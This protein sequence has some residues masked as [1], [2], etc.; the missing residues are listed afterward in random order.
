MTSDEQDPSNSNAAEQAREQSVSERA[1]LAEDPPSV[2]PFADGPKPQTMYGM[3]ALDVFGGVDDLFDVPTLGT[4]APSGP[5]AAAPGPPPLPTIAPLGERKGPPPPKT[6]S[7]AVIPVEPPKP[8]KSRSRPKISPA[9]KPAAGVP[10]ALPAQ[11]QTP[12]ATS[13]KSAPLPSAAG[14]IAKIRAAKL[15]EEPEAS[16]NEPAAP[17]RSVAPPP[18]PANE[19]EEPG[20]EQPELARPER[21]ATLELIEIHGSK[22]A[23][24]AKRE[25]VEAPLRDTAA[26]TEREEE[27]THI[28]SSLRSDGSGSHVRGE[29]ERASE[30]SAESSDTSLTMAS[31][32]SGSRAIGARTNVEKS[33]SKRFAPPPPASKKPL[34]PP[35]PSTSAD[36]AGLPKIGVPYEPPALILKQDEQAESPAQAGEVEAQ[37]QAQ[38]E[39]EER[40][41]EPPR[42]ARL[43]VPGSRLPPASPPVAAR[44]AAVASAQ[45][46]AIPIGTPTEV[47]PQDTAALIDG[48]ANEIIAES[49]REAAVTIKAKTLPQARQESRPRQRR[50]IALYFLGA[51][52]ALSLIVALLPSSGSSTATEPEPEP[53]IDPTELLEPLVEPEPEPGPVARVEPPPEPKPEPLLAVPP[54][55][56]ETGGEP[57]VAPPEPEPE[58]KPEPKT[59]PKTKPKSTPKPEPKT[60]PKPEPKP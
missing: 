36:G 58:P 35:P 56:D 10:S 59:E 2:P 30:P 4:K 46:T 51:A 24:T 20:S 42:P 9:T 53:E 32:S 12:V 34:A 19:V 44:I 17:P 43:P 29:V 22:P 21:P 50:K 16:G 23:A 57:E 37:A 33:E 5:V 18:A 52:A 48:L 13:T 26:S 27:V 3:P 25:L 55:T 6:G 41:V 54:E 15:K 7:H 8:P 60:E 1:G 28:A 40:R 47:A 14:L 11:N 38:A 45:P 49:E 39:P 31:S